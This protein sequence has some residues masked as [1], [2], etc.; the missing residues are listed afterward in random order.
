MSVFILQS[1]FDVD[2][3]SAKSREESMA[4]IPI[5]RFGKPD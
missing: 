1:E 2:S 3:N 5:G 4:T